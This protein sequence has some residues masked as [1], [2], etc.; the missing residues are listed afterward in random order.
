[1]EVAYP[2]L[3][4]WEGKDLTCI[5]CRSLLAEEVD[6]SCSK[7]SFESSLR[8]IA[9]VYHALIVAGQQAT[10]CDVI[11]IGWSENRFLGRKPKTV[12][13]SQYDEEN[14]KRMFPCQITDLPLH[15]A[16]DPPTFSHGAANL[17]TSRDRELVHLG[18]NSQQAIDPKCKTRCA[19]AATDKGPRVVAYR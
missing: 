16:Q 17:Q 11:A 18:V 13:D 1:M 8:L 14:L 12:K 4:Y 7:T 15:C 19:A 2:K 6:V 3:A 10:C 5:R 9:G